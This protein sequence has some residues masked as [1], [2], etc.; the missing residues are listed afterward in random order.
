VLR[1]ARAALARTKPALFG[2]LICLFASGVLYLVTLAPTIQGFDSAELTVGAYSLGFVHAPGYPLYTLIGHLFAQLPIGDVGLRLN[3]MSAFF[4]VVTAVAYYGLLQ[5]DTGSLLPSLAVALLVA[6]TPLFW[7]Q[8][9]RAEVYT[10]QTFLIASA[11]LAWLHAHR[12][13]R[14]VSYLVC[15]LLLGLG[16]GNHLTMALLWLTILVSAVWSNAQWRRRTLGGSALGLFVGGALYLYFPWRSHFGP[17]VDYI[18]TYFGVDPGS[19]EG[20]WWLVSGRMFHCYFYFDFSLPS[21]VQEFSRLVSLLWIGLLGV[22]LILGLWGWLRIRRN[23]PEWNRVL[24]LYFLLNVAAFLFYHVVDKEV[25]FIPLVLVVGIWAA[26]GLVA[27]VDW[28]PTRL[29]RYS[30]GQIDIMV[31]GMLLVVVVLGVTLNWPAVDS[32]ADRRAYDYAAGMLEEVEASTTI[33]NHWVSASVIDYLQMVEGQR[34]DVNNLNLDFL[35]LAAQKQCGVEGDRVLEQAWSTWLERQT[36]QARL[37][38]TEP[39]PV[40]P[41]GKVWVEDGVCW[42]IAPSDQ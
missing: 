16:M 42:R 8:A 6:T 24:T 27:F 19:L 21:L 7:S 3:L 41:G 23:D 22:G 12:S 26:N 15:F 31:N 20:L 28:V 17:G 34:P 2:I 11:L 30:R 18:G 13:Q 4:G 37:C 14:A 9:I 10:L 32:H 1:W 35:L 25:M 29:L 5:F 40:L 33:V 38:F 39:L 36:E